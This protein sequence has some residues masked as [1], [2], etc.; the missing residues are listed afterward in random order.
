[1]NFRRLG[2]TGLEVSEIGF[3][4]WAIGG[5]SWGP[6]DD[7]ES[8]RA[9]QKAIDLGVNFIDTAD[10]YGRGH[11]ETLILKALACRKNKYYL[12]T[13]V[14]NDFY[15]KEG[16]PALKNFEPQYIRFAVEQ[17]LKR[18]KRECIDVYQLHNPATEIIERGEVFEALDGLKEQGKIGF[19][20]V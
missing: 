17:S 11:S 1:M 5:T 3:G 18:L 15:Y 2:R 19:Y 9:I 6:T 20:G 12:A 4:A 10:I 13:K 8:V 14:G 7:D 16:A